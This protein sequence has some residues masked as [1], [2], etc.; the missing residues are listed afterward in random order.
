MSFSRW[1]P[2]ILAVLNLLVAPMSP[3]KFQLK[4]PYGL[5]EMWFEEFQ[6]GCYGGH[7]EYRNGMILAILNFYV[8]PIPPTK[9]EFSPT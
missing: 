8:T 4:Y 3:T 7:H 1:P 6:D 5:Q 2:W 9:F